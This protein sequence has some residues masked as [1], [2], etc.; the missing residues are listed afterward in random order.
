MT[1]YYYIDYNKTYLSYDYIITITNG[2]ADEFMYS[3]FKPNP[4]YPIKRLILDKYTSM[5]DYINSHILKNNGIIIPPKDPNIREISEL[6]FMFI[7]GGVIW[8]I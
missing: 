2:T 8:L 4:N 1:K 3:I 6:E 5:M 7:I